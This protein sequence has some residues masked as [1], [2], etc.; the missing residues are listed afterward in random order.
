MSKYTVNTETATEIL[1]G[2]LQEREKQELSNVTT[3]PN[4][5]FPCRS[6]G[7]NKLSVSK[8]NGP[9]GNIHVL[10]QAFSQDGTNAYL[11]TY[12][13]LIL[14]PISITMNFNRV[15]CSNDYKIIK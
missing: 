4:G 7:C 3:L 5:R 9:D 6:P 13:A 2:V 12:Y 8:I 15:H 14:Y 1:S 11:A 10:L